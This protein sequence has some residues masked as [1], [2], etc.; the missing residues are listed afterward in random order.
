MIV[1]I[2]EV[3]TYNEYKPKVL[4]VILTKDKI[5]DVINVITSLLNQ[6]HHDGSNVD[7]SVALADTGSNFDSRLKWK[8]YWEKLD[9]VSK[10]RIIKIDG[11]KY[12]FARCN[13][14]IIENLITPQFCPE[15]IIF[16][17]NDVEII[18][19]NTIDQ[20]LN[21][22]NLYDN[23]GTIGVMSLL[24]I[25]VVQHSG[26]NIIKTGNNQYGF[27][28]INAGTHDYDYLPRIVAGNSGMFLMIKTELF[29]KLGMFNENT[30]SCLEDVILNVDCL[31]NGYLN[32]NVGSVIVYHQDGAT[33]KQNMDSYQKMLQFD[34]QYINNYLNQKNNE[35][36]TRAQLID[37]FVIKG[38]Y[39]P[40]VVR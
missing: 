19:D 24:P 37:P 40:M 4:A 26:I 5:P 32:I 35:G 25:G 2:P 23:V 30:Q 11:L 9:V 14:Q 34:V 28:H 6:K 16:V 3:V 1:D 10:S 7:I 8:K 12:H 22:Y 15:V 13:N 31:I 29:A 33:R 20:M 36:F 27:N 17:N 18:Q 38:M 21:C 39:K